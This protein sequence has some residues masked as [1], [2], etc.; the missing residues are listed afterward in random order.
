[1]SDIY[2]YSPLWDKW[3]IVSEI[4][5]GLYGTVYKI[6][7]E[8]KG[9]TVFGVAKHI[10]VNIDE[11]LKEKEDTNK[12]AEIV[13]EDEAELSLAEKILNE[14]L[15]EIETNY[16]FASSKNLLI[17]EE[18]TVY[19]K[20]YSTGYDIFIRMPYYESLSDILNKGG[21]NNYEKIKLGIDICNALTDLENKNVFHGDIKPENIFRDNKGNFL[22]A[23]F[24]IE[25]RPE[26]I[27]NKNAVKQNVNF[28]APELQEN[29]AQKNTSDI[30]SLG[31]LLYKLF[32]KNNEPFLN[33]N[34]TSEEKNEAIL[35][36]IK[37][38]P[39]PAPSEADKELSKIILIACQFSP[40]ARWMNAAAF[41]NALLGYSS[42]KSDKFST[43]V[44]D[45]AM[46]EDIISE[47]EADNVLTQSDIDAFES[48][49]ELSDISKLQETKV[50][51]SIADN[52][53]DNS[54]FKD[55]S[56]YD[57]FTDP[58]FAFDEDNK[59]KSGKSKI[60]LIITIIVVVL[61][62]LGGCIYFAVSTNIFGINTSTADSASTAPATESTT[63]IIETQPT[64]T[65]PTTAKPTEKPTEEPTP[66]P[67]SV[68]YI[69]GMDYSSAMDE[70]SY[71]GLYAS[72]DSYEYSDYY[73]ANTIM[74]VEPSE[75]TSLDAGDT[76]SIVISQGPKPQEETS[77]YVLEG[78]DSRL[79]D[80]SEISSMDDRMLT[81]AINEIY[82]RYGYIFT[83]PYLS[84]YFNS[85]TWYN[86]QYTASEFNPDW[87]ND[88]ENKNIDTITKVMKEK[89]YR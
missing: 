73:E 69:V 74:S 51:D 45:G 77:S 82:A 12:I 41:K 24:G 32:N 26:D 40:E 15:K 52:F 70:L 87:F 42:K 6:K 9:K 55:E 21:L 13:L 35:K 62:L 83:T 43:A 89:G 85:K 80:K 65:E 47:N 39:F 61:A 76:V 56:D 49:G 10:V 57:N 25:K 68:P 60:A 81:L 84:E 33:E 66:A 23:D 59:K 1:M 44:S 22:L 16:S 4:G 5:S 71:V 46:T 8:E 75:G 38:V 2:S 11:S 18:H 54:D 28:M 37:G 78:S 17:Y 27:V 7:T 20:E 67:V 30:Y 79:I 53:E 34:S 72:I 86:P 48:D 58:E 88:Y 50:F 29:K 3:E 19:E 64:S 63:K 31:L 36:R 14:R